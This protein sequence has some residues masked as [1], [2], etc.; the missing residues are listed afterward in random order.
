MDPNEA[1]D[2]ESSSKRIYILSPEEFQ[3]LYGLPKFTEQERVIYFS[4]STEEQAKI[5]KIKSA[6]HKMYFALLL[7]Y[8]K[9]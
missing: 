6:P 9:V 1:E 5:Q 2:F 4:L 3:A 7:G 8:F